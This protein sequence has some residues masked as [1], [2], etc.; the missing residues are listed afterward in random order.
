MTS[1]KRTGRP[2]EAKAT[3][4]NFAYD[5]ILERIVSGEYPVNERL[6]SEHILSESLSVSRPVLREALSRLRDDGLIQ[7]QRGSGS[8]VRQRPSDMVL[9]FAPLSSIS[10]MQRCFEFRISLEGDAAFL[11]A[12][13]H[14]DAS[15]K[16][17]EVAC[18]RLNEAIKTNTVGVDEDFEFHLAIAEAA[19]N[20]FYLDTLAT[21]KEN[22]VV[23]MNLTRNLSLSRPK[24]R[25][26]SV[27]HEHEQI[28]EAIAKRDAN[29]A[30]QLTRDHLEAAKK[31][32][33]EGS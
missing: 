32:V 11:A 19:D 3:L 1:A 13:R 33:F 8:Y 26:L 29:M 24:E 25:L 18:N 20:H 27:Q 5:R 30:R 28:M 10:D 15:L 31:R 9:R 12:Q 7:S 6:P 17:I 16:R 2:S 14:N 23:G 22:I 21:L 4:G